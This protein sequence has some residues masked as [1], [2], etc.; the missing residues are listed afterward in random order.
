VPI[1]K[2][3]A[4]AAVIIVSLM[5]EARDLP[6]ENNVY[7][8]ICRETERERES[9]KYRINYITPPFVLPLSGIGT[10]FLL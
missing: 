10:N 4:V 1:T 9:Y 5:Y 2:S 7:V 3:V 8:C 6:K